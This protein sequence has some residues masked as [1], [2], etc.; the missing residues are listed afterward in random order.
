MSD[1]I[2]FPKDPSAVLR[3]HGEE[4]MRKPWVK[5]VGLERRGQE[6]KFVIL[7]NDPEAAKAVPA[8]VGGYATSVEYPQQVRAA[9]RSR[10]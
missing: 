5:G 3:E 9:S 2:P 1:P 7:A 6:M 4:W 8:K 10:R